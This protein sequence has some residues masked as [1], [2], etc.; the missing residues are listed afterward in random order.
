MRLQSESPSSS[1]KTIIVT[2]VILI[3]G[4]RLVYD[5]YWMSVLTLQVKADTAF[6]EAMGKRCGKAADEPTASN[7]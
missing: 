4:A 6:I 2:L 7:P 5:E 1:L 3:G